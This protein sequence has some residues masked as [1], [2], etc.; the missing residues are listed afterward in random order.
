[1]L[2][3]LKLM[4]GLENDD[5]VD[6]KL[7]LIIST[8]TARLKVLLGGLEP[9]EDLEYIIREVSIIRFNK[10]G[11]EG[12]KSQAVEGESMTFDDNDFNGFMDEIQAFLDSQADSARGKLRFL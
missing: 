2:K 12:M 4:L 1:M 3:D 5:S 9:P 11:S 7:K 8:S 6:A 10:I